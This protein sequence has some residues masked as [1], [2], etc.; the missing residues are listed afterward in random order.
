MKASILISIASFHLFYPKV[1]SIVVSLSF[2]YSEELN[3]LAS[4]VR[5]PMAMFVIGYLE[6]RIS[7]LVNTFWQ[8]LHYLLLVVTHIV[9]L[10]LG[11]LVV[12]IVMLFTYLLI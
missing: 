1:R 9:Q 7:F 11:V 5:F 4:F 12:L 8:G 3:A 6:P 10:F 2:N